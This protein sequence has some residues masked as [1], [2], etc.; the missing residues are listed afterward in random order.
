MFLQ[1]SIPVSTQTDEWIAAEVLKDE[2][3]HIQSQLDSPVPI[4]DDKEA[5]VN[6]TARFLSHIV[7]SIPKDTQSSSARIALLLNVV[8]FFTSTYLASTDVHSLAASYESDIRKIVLAAY[9]HAIA[10]LKSTGVTP[11]SQ[12]KSALLSAAVA[13][14]AS[15][16]ALFGGQGTNEVYFDELQNL[17]D[18]YKPFVAPYLQTL[19]DEILTPLVEDE[20]D[21][22]FYTFGLD[23]VAWLSGTTPRPA[24]AYLASVPISFPLIGLTQLLQYLITCHVANLTPGDLRAKIAGTTGHSQGIVSAIVISAS[25]TFDEFTENS[26]KALKWLFYSGLRGQQAFPITAIEPGMMQDAIDGGEGTPTPMLSVAG[27]SYKDLQPHIDVTNKH[28]AP[29][30]QIAVSLYNGPKTHVITGP[31]KSLFG[32]VTRLRGIKAQSGLDQSKIPFSQRKPVFSVR[33]LSVGVPYHSA[34]LSEVSEKV[35]EED[36]EGEELWQ[37]TDLKIPVY[38]TDDGKLYLWMSWSGTLTIF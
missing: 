17:Y 29:N 11:P 26:R 8:K 3:L 38:N 32:L 6:F 1:L 12:P 33:F 27:L 15:I 19:V 14:K 36:L 34:Y 9:F 20:E 35:I 21:S 22:T 28:L 24:V 31:A 4:E 37:A 23:V 18:I 5:E 10:T 13:D 2:F 30:A 25:G 7:D 16:Y